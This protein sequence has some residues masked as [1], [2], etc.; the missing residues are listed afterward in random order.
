MVPLKPLI[1]T[2][3]GAILTETEINTILM[4]A[5]ACITGRPLAKLSENA[6]DE[7]LSCMT[8]SHLIIGKTLR[9]IHPVIH[10]HIDLPRKNLDLVK[11]WKIRD[12]LTKLFWSRWTKEYLSEL[13]QYHNNNQF[14]TNS[15]PGDYCLVLTE[16][17]E[18]MIDIQLL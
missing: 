11:R 3:Q 4:D 1:K 17:Q 12:K 2:L 18:N 16:K 9:A 14:K 10:Q 5:E 7:N 6:D 8:P 13:R 15:K